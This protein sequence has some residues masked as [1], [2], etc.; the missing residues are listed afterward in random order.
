MA[1]EGI[2]PPTR[3]FSGRQRPILPGLSRSISDRP[4]STYDRPTEYRASQR[5]LEYR[6]V[7]VLI[8]YGNSYPL[9]EIHHNPRQ[10]RGRMTIPRNRHLAYCLERRPVVVARP[11]QTG[12]LLHSPDSATGGLPG[13][14]EYYRTGGRCP[15]DQRVGHASVTLVGRDLEGRGREGADRQVAQASSWRQLQLLPARSGSAHPGHWLWWLRW[16]LT[17]A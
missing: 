8:R 12:D 5:T 1:R 15:L 7:Q 13:R 14:S 11:T 10:R 17:G 3:G 6:G 16:S 2:D 4:A 9:H